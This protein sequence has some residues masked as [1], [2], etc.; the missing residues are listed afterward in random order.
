M[1]PPAFS[2]GR[3]EST[4]T[5]KAEL[6]EALRTQLANAHGGSS[7]FST[8][9]LCSSSPGHTFTNHERP[10]HSLASSTTSQA[11][12]NDSAPTASASTRSTRSQANEE[13]QVSRAS[14]SGIELPAQTITG[15][16]QRSNAAYF[17]T[18]CTA[19]DAWF[20]E[21]G[22]RRGTLIECFSDQHGGGAEL[23]ALWLA[24]QAGAV[25]GHLV[26][27]DVSGWFYPPAAAAWGI[28]L[29]RLVVIRPQRHADALWS[30][31]QALRCT[32]V[33]AVWG[34]LDQFNDRWFRR[35]QLAARSSR[36]IGVLLR[37]R[38]A[39]GRPSWADLQMSIR[40]PSPQ[41]LELHLLRAMSL[42]VP[43]AIQLALQPEH[44]TLKVAG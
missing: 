2:S 28:D 21:H 14:K 10:E 40:R 39:Q 9:P 12:S 42:T 20:P 6:L 34:H 16:S 4:A 33:K 25:E 5:T 26:V 23:L 32:A 41:R 43:K 3:L 18:G 35:F 31:E 17:S 36:A 37:P 30:F 15:R 13:R 8:E 11:T 24:R 22:L 27:I 29:Q 1:K 44:Q 7:S 19:W 38:Q